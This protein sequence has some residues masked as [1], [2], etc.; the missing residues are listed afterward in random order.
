MKDQRLVT[1]ETIKRNKPLPR[2]AIRS[3]WLLL[4]YLLDERPDCRGLIAVGKSF[5]ELVVNANR[6]VKFLLLFV[7]KA[8]E[9]VKNDCVRSIRK[10]ASKR[11]KGFWRL[12]YSLLLRHRNFHRRRRPRLFLCTKDQVRYKPRAEIR[13]PC[14]IE[15]LNAAIAFASSPF[16][17]YIRPSTADA[18]AFAGANAS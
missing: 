2:T 13:V 11:S 14:A 10:A 5:E 1:F 17:L 4:L 15:R 12:R 6:V 3:N 9:L 16:S 18:S 7:N 8:K